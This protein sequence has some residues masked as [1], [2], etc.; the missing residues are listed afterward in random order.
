MTQAQQRPKVA[1]IGILRVDGSTSP[2]AMESID[3]LK[4]GLSNLGYV[5][6]QNINF[7]IRGAEN[8]LDRLPL[9]AAELV[10]LKVDTIVTG[11]PQATKVAKEATNTIPIVMGRMDDVV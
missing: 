5:E 6:G 10:Q 2:V 7:E 4:R 1:R 3:D 8:K 9:L 11:G